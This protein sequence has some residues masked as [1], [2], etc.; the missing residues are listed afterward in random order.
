MALAEGRAQERD[1][2]LVIRRLDG[3]VVVVVHPPITSA[4][5]AELRHA[6]G[7]LVEDQG[8]LHVVLELPDLT[9]P[10][11]GLLSLLVETA[12]QLECRSGTFTARTPVGE[13]RPSGRRPLP[14]RANTH[15]A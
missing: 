15:C 8:N 6:L 12:D 7:D 9:A 13:W 2:P 3:A 4:V 11:G 1:A 5:V 14:A 10:D